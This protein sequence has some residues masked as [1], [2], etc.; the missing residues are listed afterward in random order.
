MPDGSSFSLVGMKTDNKSGWDIA[1]KVQERS[2]KLYRHVRRRKAPHVR[3]RAMEMK[4]GRRQ[5]GSS[6]RRLLDRVRDDIKEK[7]LTGKKCATWRRM[8]SY[9]DHIKVG[10]RWRGRRRHSCGCR[11]YQLTFIV[12]Y[13]QVVW[14]WEYCNERGESCRL[15]LSVHAIAVEKQKTHPTNEAAN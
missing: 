15:T 13:I 4:E 12:I 1:K 9:I 7:G 14:C 5:R 3:R 11:A 6:K 8:L 2:L 10:I